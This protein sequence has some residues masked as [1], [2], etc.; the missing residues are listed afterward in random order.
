MLEVEGRLRLITN[1]WLQQVG[2]A[3]QVRDPFAKTAAMCRN[4]YQGTCG[5]M[6]DDAFRKEFM[7]SLPAPKFKFTIAKAFELV[8]VIGPS[9]FWDYPGRRVQQY[10]EVDWQIEAFGDPRDPNVQF[11]F[12]SFMQDYRSQRRLNKTRCSLMQDYL[13]Y[14]Q[15]EQPNGGLRAEGQL[16]IVEALLMGRG[17]LWTEPY[18][19]PGSN[20]T[21]IG[22]FFDSCLRLFIDPECTKQN[23]SDCR[24]IAR[25]HVED[26]WEVERKFKLPEGSLK[27]YAVATLNDGLDV[28]DYTKAY[29]DQFHPQSV[30]LSSAGSGLGS[31]AKNKI[32]W[33][34]IFSRCGVGTRLAN[35]DPVLHE[36]FESTV[37][38]FARICVGVGVPFPLNFPPT[39][40][41]NEEL[42]EDEVRAALDWPVP[43]YRDNRWPV[44][45]MDFYPATSGAWPIAP[46]AMGLG[47][48]M[49]MNVIMSCLATRVYTNSKNIV[50]YLTSAGEDLMSKLAGNEFDIFIP[51]N[52]NAHKSVQEI[53][54]YIQTPAVNYD[55]FKVFDYVAMMFDKRVGLTDSMYGLNVGGKVARTAADINLKENATSVRPDW[56]ARCVEDWMTAAANNER[57]CAGWNVRGQDVVARYGPSGARLWDQLISNEDPEVYV[58]EMNMTVEANSVRKPNKLRDTENIS[59]IAQYLIPEMSRVAQMTGNT[60]PLNKFIKSLGDA[61]DQDV[62]E[63][64]LPD[65]Q[66]PPPPD[67]PPQGPAPDPEMAQPEMPM[68]PEQ[69]PLDDLPP[70]F[71]EMM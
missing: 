62:S 31:V 48:L 5:F 67:A 51:I 7:S 41:K 18:K 8:A 61:M 39:M 47:E 16:G 45:V 30:S 11:M 15:R 56:M 10:Q 70:G 53:L 3:R 25:Q 23:L 44:S 38:D 40:L 63:W 2:L 32:V 27:N 65:L 12:E 71:M 6:W 42:T 66:P 55:V 43:Y 64:V 21:M 36:A 46:L 13:N 58:R 28:S 9:L 59:R 49:F 33:Y 35:F 37:G 19:F 50:G 60:E 4:F 22:S 14:S 29:T 57:I 26:Y 54:S 17:C 1:T 24:W 68:G 20:R 52:D 34:E 69:P